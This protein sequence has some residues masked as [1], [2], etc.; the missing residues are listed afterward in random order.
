MKIKCSAIKDRNGII[1]LGSSHSKILSQWKGIIIPEIQGFYTDTNKFVN[2]TEALK[3]AK[4]AG[5]I[6]NK[7]YP[8]NKLFSED[9]KDLPE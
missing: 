6:K 3:I 5:Q 9:L 4:K 8:K 7:T 2:R 1:F